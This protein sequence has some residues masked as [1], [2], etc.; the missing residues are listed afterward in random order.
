M[1]EGRGNGS[2]LTIHRN[3]KFSTTSLVLGVEYHFKTNIS[4]ALTEL[5]CRCSKRPGV[6]VPVTLMKGTT[7]TR[8]KEH[9]RM[10]FFAKIPKAKNNIVK[11]RA[12]K[13]PLDH[14]RFIPSST[15]VWV[16]D[17]AH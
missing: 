17:Q 16:P 4:I 1:V 15:E 7:V 3:K 13:S 2:R 12:K 11:P 14:R 9:W 8:R 6:V 10:S 5:M